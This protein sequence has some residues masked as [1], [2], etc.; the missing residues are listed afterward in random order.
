MS[1]AYWVIVG[2]LFFVVLGLAGFAFYR[3]AMKQSVTTVPTSTS[4]TPKI[5]KSESAIPL[6]VT[7]P[8]DG[9]EVTTPAISVSGR[10]SKGADVAVNEKDVK[11]DT[12]GNFL[13]TINLEEGENFISVIASDEL[14]NVSEKEITVTYTPNE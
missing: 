10:T 1:R 12:D 4:T 6:T 7:F 2:I 8:T 9:L 13:V 14:G 5:I 11:A 3:S